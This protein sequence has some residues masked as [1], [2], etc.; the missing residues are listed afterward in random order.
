MNADLRN[1]GFTWRRAKGDHRYWEHPDV[2]EAK[3][4]LDGR[5]GDDAKPYQVKEVRKVIALAEHARKGTP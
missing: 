1:A 3:L 2:P 4:S 5:D